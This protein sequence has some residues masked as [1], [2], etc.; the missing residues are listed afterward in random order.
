MKALLLVA[1]VIL[2]GN[3]LFAGEHPEWKKFFA[4]FNVHGCVIIYDKNADEFHTYNEA[5]CDSA[6]LPASTYKLLNTLIGLETGVI[7]GIDFTLEWDGVERFYDMWN[8]DHALP[9][10]IKYSVVWWYQEAARRIGE[11]RMQTYVDSV[12]YGNRNIGGGID[13][14]WLDGDL[15]ITP[16]EQIAFLRS[17]DDYNLP[18]SKENIDILKSIIIQDEST[19]E[20]TIRAKTG[21][22]N[23]ESNIGWYVG[24]VEKDD[25][26]WYFAV[27][28]ESAEA[29]KNFVAS[30]KE[31]AFD[32]L[33][34]LKVID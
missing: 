16:R 2:I 10:A 30:R 27:N 21:W 22:A 19:E 14:F 29:H 24:W 3:N 13:R 23:N 1:A 34:Y 17:I 20:Y 8:K 7:T 31:I 9:T 33:R 12:G 4:S 11:E 15:R 5:R 6:F 26:V 32:T 28:V 25:N 18:F